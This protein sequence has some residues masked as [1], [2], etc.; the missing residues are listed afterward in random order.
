MKHR[1]S[2]LLISALGIAALSGCTSSP[3]SVNPADGSDVVIPEGTYAEYDFRGAGNSYNDYFA[4][5]HLY[6]NLGVNQT[7]KIDAKSL[8]NSVAIDDVLFVSNNSDVVTVDA[9]GKMKGVAKGVT[10]I[11]VI[12]KDGSF[13]H[14]VRVSVSSSLSG[15]EKTTVLNN[16]SA[17]YADESYKAPTKVLRYEYSSEIYSCEGVV[18]HGMEGVEAMGYDAEQGYFF[19]DGPA[20]YYKTLNGAP[21]VKNGKWIMYPV[22]SGLKTRL[23][24]ITPTAKNYCDINTASYTSYDRIIR[25]VL[26]FFF[27]SGEK[28]L[29]DLLADFEGKADFEDFPTYSATSMS[30]PHENGIVFNYASTNQSTTIGYDDEINYV[31]IPADTVCESDMFIKQLI[32]N[33]R[34]KGIDISSEYRYQLNG[35]NWTR[36]FDRSQI[37]ES[38]FETTKISNPKDNGF[39]Q[40]DSLYDL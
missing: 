13:T 16:I 31:D 22:N 10:D 19:V 36:K 12:A 14:K 17:I 23:I 2:T 21:E 15:D 18:H 39:K 6:Y 20:V 8:P 5:N 7:K 1:F 25:D 4:L 29:T 26:N 38:D 9:T 28:I 33:G 27:V 35:Q 24:H 11:D 34:T 32:E 3:D 30:S 40:V 37:F